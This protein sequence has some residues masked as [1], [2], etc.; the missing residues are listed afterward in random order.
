MNFD[1]FSGYFGQALIVTAALEAL[2]AIMAALFCLTFAAFV[3][4][5]IGVWR[6][7]RAEDGL[8]K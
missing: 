4:Y 5:L 8:S 6:L 2:N 3:I 7:Y 1:G